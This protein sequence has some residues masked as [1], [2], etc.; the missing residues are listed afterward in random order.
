MATRV[1]KSHRKSKAK[2]SY[3]S[4]KQNIKKLE[5]KGYIIDKEDILKKKDFEKVYNE[6][7]AR[8]KK[9]I[10]RDLATDTLSYLYQRYQKHIESYKKKNYKLLDVIQDKQQFA[11]VYRNVKAAKMSVKEL[12]KYSLAFNPSFA[13]NYAKSIDASDHDFDGYFDIKPHKYKELDEETGEERI[14]YTPINRKKLESDIMSGEFEAPKL[15]RDFVEKHN[16]YYYDERGEHVLDSVREAFE[17]MY[18]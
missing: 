11:D 18:V 1:Y 8:G 13:K 7:K 15:F 6:W 14:K 4:Y 12:A 17:G 9:N 3:G 16:G 2:T 5:K 10:A